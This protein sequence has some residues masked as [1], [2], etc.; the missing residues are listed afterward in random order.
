MGMSC[1]RSGSRGS[2]MIESFFFMKWEVEIQLS[3]DHYIKI[4]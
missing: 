2:I 3:Q 1:G 4:Y